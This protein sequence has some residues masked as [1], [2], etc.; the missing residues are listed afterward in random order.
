MA[1][2]AGVMGE[3]GSLVD[4]VLNSRTWSE[5]SGWSEPLKPRHPATDINLLGVYDCAYVALHYMASSSEPTN[6]SQKEAGRKETKSLMLVSSTAAYTDSPM[7]PDYQ[8]SKCE[9]SLCAPFP[10][11]KLPKNYSVKC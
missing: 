10:V 1:L 9:C 5:D 2:V 8:V 7:F 11:H 3:Q 4:Q 6:G